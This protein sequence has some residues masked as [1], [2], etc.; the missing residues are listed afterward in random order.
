MPH[1]IAA[2]G[3]RRKFSREGNVDNFL[4]LFRLLT[5]VQMDLHKTLADKKSYEIIMNPMVDM[6]AQK[7][8]N[9]PKNAKN[10]NLLKTKRTLNIKMQS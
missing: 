8:E 4:I 9:T 7:N 1:T 5:K 3:A 2:S 6:L 10:N